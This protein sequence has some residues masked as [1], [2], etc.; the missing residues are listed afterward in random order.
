MREAQGVRGVR[1]F[2]VLVE[3]CQLQEP[4]RQPTAGQGARLL[5]H[6]L[7][8][9]NPKIH[10]ISGDPRE[11]LLLCACWQHAAQSKLGFGVSTTGL[12]PSPMHQALQTLEKAG[13]SLGCE[14]LKY[15]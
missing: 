2:H 5:L 9:A 12:Q 1:G 7:H 6:S 8:G 13:C 10:C 4:A 3:D 11:R 14:Q 15:S